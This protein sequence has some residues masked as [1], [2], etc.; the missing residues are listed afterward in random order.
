MTQIDMGDHIIIRLVGWKEIA[1]YHGH[2]SYNSVIR[3]YKKHPENYY[4]FGSK[5]IYSISIQKNV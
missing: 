3:D 2:K 1:E 4:Y 5:L